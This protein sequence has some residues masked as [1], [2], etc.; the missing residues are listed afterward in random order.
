MRGL[1]LGRLPLGEGQG[2]LQVP[3]TL[4]GAGLER[5]VEAPEHPDLALGP[6]R[7][8]Q[9][10]PAARQGQGDHHQNE[11]HRTSSR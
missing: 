2:G 4:L 6:N 1:D 9:S 11:L 7:E 8:P 10:R 3:R 5:G